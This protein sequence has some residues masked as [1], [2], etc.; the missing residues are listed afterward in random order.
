VISL[1]GFIDETRELGRT[2]IQEVMQDLGDFRKRFSTHPY[3]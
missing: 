3:T 1:F 2:T